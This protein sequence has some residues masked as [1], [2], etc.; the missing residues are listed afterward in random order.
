MANR[1]ERIDAAIETAE[2]NSVPNAESIES[3]VAEST[4][5]GVVSRDRYAVDV[6][7]V[8]EDDTDELFGL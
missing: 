5:A 3:I 8:L 4:V 7:T 1:G 6:D 2:F